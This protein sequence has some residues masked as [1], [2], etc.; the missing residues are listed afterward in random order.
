MQRATWNWSRIEK[1]ESPSKPKE[2]MRDNSKSKDPE[3]IEDKL[4]CFNLLKVFLKLKLTTDF[5]MQISETLAQ[6]I[7][8]IFIK[9]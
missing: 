2:M 6:D 4:S 8:D 1:K 7:S 3:Q 9:R 5:W